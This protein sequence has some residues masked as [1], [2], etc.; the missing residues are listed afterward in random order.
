MDGQAMD[1]QAMDEQTDGRARKGRAKTKAGSLGTT[2][3]GQGA[4]REPAEANTILG[5]GACT[6]AN[7]ILKPAE[8]DIILGL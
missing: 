7:T 4:C 1:E 8:A 6:E 3:L 5:Q 2:W